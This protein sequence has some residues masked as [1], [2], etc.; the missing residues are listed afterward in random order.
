[1]LLYLGYVLMH[2]RLLRIELIHP[3][4]MMSIRCRLFT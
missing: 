4:G 3:L 1:M 2:E